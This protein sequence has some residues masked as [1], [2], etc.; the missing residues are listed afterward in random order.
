M[1][2]PSP[3]RR[4]RG[5]VTQL[6]RLAPTD[7]D[8]VLDTLDPDQRSRVVSLLAGMQTVDV[9][10]TD[11]PSAA[12]PKGKLVLPDDLAPWLAVRIGGSGDGEGD[13]EQPFAMTRDASAALRRRAASLLPQPVPEPPPISLASLVMTKLGLRTA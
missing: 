7:F 5:A 2:G 10:E 11:E 9:P 3:D 13:N 8:A 12:S 1:S 4:L 6:R